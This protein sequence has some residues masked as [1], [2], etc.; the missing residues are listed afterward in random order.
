MA[1]SVAAT[2]VV[3]TGY[4]AWRASNAPIGRGRQGDIFRGDTISATKHPVYAM[5]DGDRVQ[6]YL[7][8]GSTLEIESAEKVAL[9]SGE[10]WFMITPNSGAFQVDAAETR[11][12][13]VGTT[14]NVSH[15]GS[16]LVVRTHSGKVRVAP[17][18]GAEAFVTADQQWNGATGQ[19][20]A[21]K[22]DNLPTRSGDL[23]DWA[24]GGA[25]D[26]AKYPSAMDAIRQAGP[27]THL[28]HPSVPA[29]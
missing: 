14:F 12:H 15:E 28:P 20:V 6:A 18:N 7:A 27:R 17:G 29:P 2:L 10:A 16:G 13:V 8:P 19:V 9:R 4:L 1:A 26:L 11:V 23:W 25:P 3:A 22:L 5:L 21:C 24:R